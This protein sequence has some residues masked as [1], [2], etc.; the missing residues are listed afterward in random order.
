MGAERNR[1]MGDTETG[2]HEERNSTATEDTATSAGTDIAATE[3]IDSIEVTGPPE[4]DGSPEAD[5][6]TEADGSPEPDGPPDPDRPTERVRPAERVRPTDRDRLTQSDRPTERVRPA[7]SAGRDDDNIFDDMYGR[8]DEEPERVPGAHRR[9]RGL[10]FPLV[11][12]VSLLVIGALVG[13]FVVP[14]AGPSGGALPPSGAVPS[15]TGSAGPSPVPTLSGLPTFPTPPARP[16]N[17]L[18]DWAE[19]ISEVTGVPS[20]AIQAYGY[21]QLLMQQTDPLCRLSW[22]TLAGIGQVES[23]HGQ[24]GGAVLES[25]GRSSPP[26]TGPLLDGK[27]GRALVRDTDAGAYDGNATYD[28][29]MGPLRLLPTVWRVHA[30]DADADGIL[31]PYDIDDAS[32]A[33]ARLLC[34]GSEDLGQLA[35]WTAAIGRMKAGDAYARTVFQEADSYGRLTRSI[36]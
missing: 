17:A 23:I 10:W 28:R 5:R 3:P 6:P 11:V 27:E 15:S 2:E 7:G 30:I 29:A 31:D 33:G 35:G 8:D 36:G 24:A 16:A 13:R 21:A 19:R 20:V 12:F 14:A 9:G 32:L 18:H 22:T 25:A 26:I 34:S 1:D 4:P